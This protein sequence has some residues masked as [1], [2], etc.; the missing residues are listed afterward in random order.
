MRDGSSP[1]AP[2]RYQRQ[3]GIKGGRT[4]IGAGVIG[5]IEKAI[6]RE[7]RRYGVS[8]SFVIAVALAGFFGIEEQEDYH[9]RPERP[10]LVKTAGGAPVAKRRSRAA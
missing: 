1:A 7:Q 3:R 10:Y 4:A 2:R 5:D 9:Q 6:L 8:R